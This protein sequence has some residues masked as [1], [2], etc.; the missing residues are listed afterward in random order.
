MDINLTVVCLHRGRFSDRSYIE[1]N[2]EIF[3]GEFSGLIVLGS[4]GSIY[5]SMGRLA[6]TEYWATQKSLF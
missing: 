2:G 1:F 5:N 6:S 3:W 4:I